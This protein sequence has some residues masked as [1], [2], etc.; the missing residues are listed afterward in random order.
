MSDI[1]RSIRAEMV[2]GNRSIDCYLF[3]D[4]EKRIGI[5]LVCVI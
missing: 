3:P 1:I 2:L 4:G 5:G